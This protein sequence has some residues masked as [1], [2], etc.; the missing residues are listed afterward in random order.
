MV[1]DL[2]TKTSPTPD[3]RRLCALIGLIDPSRQN[4]VDTRS[5]G[6]LE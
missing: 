4:A 5:G 6:V 2:M 1:A 3:F